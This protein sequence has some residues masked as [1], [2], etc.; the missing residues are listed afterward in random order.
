MFVMLIDRVDN[1]QY[2]GDPFSFKILFWFF[3]FH[4]EAKYRFTV[5]RQERWKSS[6]NFRGSAATRL[7]DTIPLRLE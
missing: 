6:Y 5:Y 1:T 4:G 3:I 7:Q 2:V